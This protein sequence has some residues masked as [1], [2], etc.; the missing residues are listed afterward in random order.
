M[1]EKVSIVIPAFN[2]E[3]TL[4][5]CLN[6]ILSQSYKNYELIIVNNNSS[7]NSEKIIREF[8][9]KSK[10]IKSFFEKQISR[11]AARNT[12]EKQAKGEIILMTDADCIVPK[13]W[14]ESMIKPI[15]KNGFDAV[16]GFQEN[17]Q[18]NFWSKQIQICAYARTE[19]NDKELIGR[20]DTKNFA[21]KTSTLKKLGF[22]NRKY[23]SG[24]DT[25]LSIKIQNNHLRLMFLNSIK[26]KHHHPSSFK[27]VITKYFYRAYWCARITRDNKYFLKNTQF[28]KRTAQTFWYFMKFFPGLITTMFTKGFKYAYFDFITGL[29]WRAGLT[30]EKIKRT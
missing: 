6:S 7:D 10:K 5:N 25:D 28:K 1:N 2:A 14:I 26:V 19:S 13:N 21:I 8:T 24:N 12:G 17:I 9:A 29:A 30:Y 27:Q 16:Q 23:L 22:S 15:I 18:N 4:K 20:I 11:G 3:N